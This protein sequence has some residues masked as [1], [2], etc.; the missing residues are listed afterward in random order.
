MENVARL[1]RT[2]L[3]DLQKMLEYA[4]L[5]PAHQ[6]FIDVLLTRGYETGTFDFLGATLA[7]YPALANNHNSLAVRSS[8]IQAH[9]RV[10]VCLDLAFGRKSESADPVLNTLKT[11][12][13]K[14]IK[15]DLAT[16]GTISEA[17]AA[18]LKVYERKTG[19]TL[20]TQV[21]THV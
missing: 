17:T 2:M 19:K 20:P 10:R 5:I 21:T 7:A 18:S 6:R 9:P 11:A 4:C 12:L 14:A 1:E 16:T 8:Q 3:P 15:H 13:V